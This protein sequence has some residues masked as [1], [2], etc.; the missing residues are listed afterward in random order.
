MEVLLVLLTV[1]AATL[2]L[3]WLVRRW[4]R[5]HQNK[6][7]QTQLDN[8]GDMVKRMREHRKGPE[9]RD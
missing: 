3:G 2:A 7:N 9:V 8:L 1:L 4:D 6:L 5:Q